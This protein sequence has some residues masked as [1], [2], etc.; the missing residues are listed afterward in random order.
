MRGAR[1]RAAAARG[2]WRAWA[3]VAAEESATLLHR[4]EVEAPAADSAL[5][6][7]A[8]RV[9][10]VVATR[11]DM[12]VQWGRTLR[13]PRVYAAMERYLAAFEA[14]RAGDADA[15]IE[16]F[17]DAWRTDSGFVFAGIMA[18]GN[19]LAA[20]RF[21][22]GDSLL[23]ALAPYEAAM[24]PLELHQYRR[25]RA[26]ARS[27]VQATLAEAREVAR[28]EPSAPFLLG[29]YAE[30]AYLANRPREAL[31]AFDALASRLGADA[32][33]PAQAM[34]RAAALHALGRHAEELRAIDAV[35]AAQPTEPHFAS[36]RLAPLAALGRGDTLRVLL[37]ALATRDDG[38][39]PARLFRGVAL[40]LQAHGYPDDAARLLAQGVAW[41]R[42][43]PL[44]A[45][46]PLARRLSAA[47]LLL[48]AGRD[49]EAAALLAP[50]AP[51]TARTPTM[52]QRSALLDLRGVLAARAGRA[53]E[54]RAIGDSLARLAARGRNGVETYRRAR[55]AA[56]LGDAEAAVLLLDQALQEGFVT[57]RELHVDPAFRRLRRDPRF[58]RVTA[59]RG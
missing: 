4:T 16:R 13:R 35:L 52:P 20:D 58:Q 43:R 6:L 28:L 57:H 25:A 51:D 40:E 8:D 47:E 34:L 44:P 22:L 53:A 27:D 37:A 54:A 48:D 26:L 36:T 56:A 42:G 21:A 55:I 46:A 15:G 45:D 10:A 23:A 24:L 39:D 59:P 2:R 49:A 33:P 29:Q 7:L 30:G 19:A 14:V 3:S 38:R 31:R 11:V 5:A 32:L 18:A 50:T 17:L 12:D 41:L 1:R 9:S